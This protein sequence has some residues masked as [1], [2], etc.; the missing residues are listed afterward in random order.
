MAEGFARHYA[1]KLAIQVEVASAGTRPEGYIHPSAITVMNEKGIDI[2]GQRSKGIKPGETLSYDY[3]ITMGCSDT[4][5]CPANFGGTVRNWGI[6]D[7]FGK[8]IEFYRQARDEIEQ[9][10]LQ[11]LEEIRSSSQRGF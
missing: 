2:S 10:V 4:G 5:V 3:V 8:A 6:E 7:P 11:L 1:K 9:K